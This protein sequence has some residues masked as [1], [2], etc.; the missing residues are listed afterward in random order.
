MGSESQARALG[1]G[2]AFLLTEGADAYLSRLGFASVERAA[3]PEGVQSSVEFQSA[4]PATAR[5]MKLELLPG[6]R[7]SP[8]RM[9]ALTSSSPTVIDLAP[10]KE[11]ALKE[12]FRVLRPGGRLAVSD[13][14][15]H[16]DLEGLP[17]SEKQVRE[18]LSW[19]GCIAGA[20]ASAEYRAYLEEAGF[21]D[22]VVEPRFP[23]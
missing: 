23:L 2:H 10:D 11:S 4:C 14:V 18:A 13:I 5:A 20:P 1:A 22:V 15:V 16:P 12:A 3:V 19:V 21:V 7:A 9:K 6:R 17:V 8:S